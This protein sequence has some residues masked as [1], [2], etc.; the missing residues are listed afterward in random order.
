MVY[1][2]WPAVLLSRGFQLGHHPGPHSY[3][4]YHGKSGH[5]N[6]EDHYNFVRQKQFP[7]HQELDAEHGCTEWR[8]RERDIL[9]AFG[10]E[11]SNLFKEA[12]QSRSPKKKSKLRVRFERYVV[13]ENVLCVITNA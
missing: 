12:F 11:T 2:P 10:E 13:F 1:R 4:L 9:E 8:D 3:H 7:G 5:A 6:E